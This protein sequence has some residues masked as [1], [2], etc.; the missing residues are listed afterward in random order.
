MIISPRLFSRVEYFSLS[1]TAWV[2]LECAIHGGS[3]QWKYWFFRNVIVEQTIW[4]FFVSTTS[5]ITSSAN[6]QWEHAMIRRL[7][8]IDADCDLCRTSETVRVTL[9]T[10]T[11]KSFHHLVSCAQNTKAK[12]VKQ[13]SQCSSFSSWS[14]FLSKTFPITNEFRHCQRQESDS[15]KVEMEKVETKYEINLKKIKFDR[16]AKKRAAS[17]L[18][19]KDWSFNSKASF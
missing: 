4:R 6:M 18:N 16:G 17:S 15:E 3:G 5:L 13:P 10:R 8:T 2:G 14:V 12:R 1:F 11:R 9:M 19:Q 7:V